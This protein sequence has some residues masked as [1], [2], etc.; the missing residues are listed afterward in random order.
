VSSADEPSLCVT[1]AL[2]HWNG[3]VV[4]AVSA[5][6]GGAPACVVS[7]AQSA[8]VQLGKTMPC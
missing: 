7:R 4:L 5:I 1:S 3:P 2:K 8:R 6:N